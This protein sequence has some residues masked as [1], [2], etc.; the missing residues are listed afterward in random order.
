M[1][2]INQMLGGGGKVKF[3]S[4][5]KVMSEY[6]AGL[7]VT[8]LTF[9]PSLVICYGTDSTALSSMCV[10]FALNNDIYGAVRHCI[11]LPNNDL[12]YS[13]YFN[14]SQMN[15]KF[16]FTDDG[17]NFMIYITSGTLLWYAFDLQI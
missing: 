6:N 13:K 8:G 2:I 12:L 7:T 10:G 4:G 1:S 11:S 9:K 14:G 5:S 15:Q 17:F 16:I 3:A